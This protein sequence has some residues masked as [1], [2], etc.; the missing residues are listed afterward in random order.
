MSAKKD[1]IKF[2][3]YTDIHTRQ[4][5]PPSRLGNYVDDTLDKVEQVMAIA[6][7]EKCDFTYCGGDVF[8][9]KRPYKTKHTLI[10]RLMRVFSK[11]GMTNYCV[12]GNH[13]ISY[14]NMGTLPDQPL[15]VM[16]ESGILVRVD[17]NS[18]YTKGNLKLH[19]DSYDFDEEPDFD[20]IARK[21]A[22]VEA[23]VYTLGAHVY[24]CPKGGSMFGSKLFS[25]EELAMTG[26]DIYLLGHYH[27]DNGIVDEAF[28][29]PRQTFINPGSL[30][31]GDHG[32]ENLD[33]TPNC[34]VVTIE[35]KGG[36]VTWLTKRIEL[37]VKPASE[38]FDLN[39]KEKLK[40][41]AKETAGFVAELE[42]TSVSHNDV[43]ETEEEELKEIMPDPFI[44]KRT[45]DFIQQARE[46]M[47]KIK[48]KAK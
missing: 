23:D 46:E 34:V 40:A 21:R 36:E 37:K 22:K 19:L 4:D 43:K 11:S 15:G 14:D 17:G 24:S 41:E 27:V 5:N 8:D 35:K 32:D 20:E 30:T 42:A 10:V 9:A 28:N 45:M 25:Y 44:Y 29:K 47:A 12:V 39:R 16:F 18:I 13:D 48:V 2:V 38:V 31:R 1:V 33:R 3:Y 26:H 6:K 7:K